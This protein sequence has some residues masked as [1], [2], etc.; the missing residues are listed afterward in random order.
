M[1]NVDK[2]TQ[3]ELYKTILDMVAI[4]SV[5]TNAEEERRMARYVYD[6][7]G[8]EPYFKDHPED[9]K[10]ISIEDDPLER[11]YVFAIVRA[12]K[13]TSK[14]IIL[15]GHMDVVSTTACGTLAPWAFNPVEYTER[16]AAVSIPDEA[17]Q[18]LETGEWLFGRGIADMKSG[19]AA[20][21]HLTRETANTRRS[22][23]NIVYLTVPDEENNSA[24]MRA[25]SKLLY[26]FATENSLEY[27]ACIDLEPTFATNGMS[28]PSIYLG[29]IG[30]VNTFFYSRG[31]ESHVGEY[32]EGFSAIPIMSYVN[33]ALEGNPLYSDKLKG[34]LYPPSVA[35]RQTDLR[36]EYSATTI[37]KGF[38]YY[39]H[40]TATKMPS[41]ILAEVV[42]VAS[43][44]ANEAVLHYDNNLSIF[45]QKG[46][47]T[48]L[49]S[50]KPTVLSY[51][52]LETLTRERLSEHAFNAFMEDALEAAGPDADE[53]DRASSVID[54]MVR[55]CM[56]EPPVTITGFL[57]PWYPHRTNE[58][59]S[60][61]EIIVA[62]AA[63]CV[64]NKA[65]TEYGI[66]LDVRPLFEGISDLSYCGF[67]GPREELEVFA[68]NMPGWGRTY[69]LPLDALKNLNIPVISF[70]PHGRDAHS[71]TERIHLSYAIDIFPELLRLLVNTI[72]KKHQ[73]LKA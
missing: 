54:S 25:A 1:K 65:Q 66:T 32:F 62:D 10:L 3:N 23:V 38:A 41:E 9:L 27:L 21:L 15:T 39:S 34:Q 67:Q 7:L 57:P 14:T 47:I 68:R 71:N 55:L 44:A 16:L 46:G 5:T 19:L 70:G 43:R 53:R 4:P 52:K 29:T 45:H 48:P 36:Q 12:K 73:D 61:G 58:R 42:G 59:A 35:M 30:K 26:E 33:L 60:D 31:K 20:G 37:S 11:D 69:S 8:E 13:P 6:K 24:G 50:W 63:D 51:E 22:D 72:V 56:L 40:L 49:K 28:T 18:D 17:R 2:Y 64:V